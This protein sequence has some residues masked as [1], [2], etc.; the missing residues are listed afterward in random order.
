LV[1]GGG[2]PQRLRT[3]ADSLGWFTT[4]LIQWR[5]AIARKREAMGGASIVVDGASAA[6]LD[7]GVRELSSLVQ[8]LARMNTNLE[9]LARTPMLSAFGG[10]YEQEIQRITVHIDTLVVT[11]REVVRALTQ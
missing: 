1:G 3:I 9:R 5:G 7:A 6:A 2:G 11:L 8:E 10:G 4:E